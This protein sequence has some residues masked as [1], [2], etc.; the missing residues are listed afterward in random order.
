MKGIRRAKKRG[1]YLKKQPIECLLSAEIIRRKE[2]RLQT[3][4]SHYTESANKKWQQS[5]MK[6][7]DE[8]QKFSH[9]K[10]HLFQLYLIDDQ[11]NTVD[12]EVDN[13]KLILESLKIA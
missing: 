3:E 12:E 6:K 10:F 5:I 13:V 11:L 9:S 1:T 7:L 8:K 4:I 2:K